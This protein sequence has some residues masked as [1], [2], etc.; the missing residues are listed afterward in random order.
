MTSASIRLTTSSYLSSQNKKPAR[1]ADVFWELEE[2]AEGEPLKNA[3][4][5]KWIKRWV[6][7]KHLLSESRQGDLADFSKMAGGSC[8]KVAVPFKAF[9]FFKPNTWSW[10]RRIKITLAL[11]R[12][13]AGKMVADSS[14]KARLLFVPVRGLNES[15]KAVLGQLLGNDDLR[16]LLVQNRF[17][18]QLAAPGLTN[19]KAS[20]LLLQAREIADEDD[21]ADGSQF[22]IALLDSVMTLPVFHVFMPE[23]WRA[24]NA[25]LTP[26][27]PVRGSPYRFI[28]ENA[29]KEEAL[30]DS[31]K[32]AFTASIEN[33]MTFQ[34]VGEILRM[35]KPI[36]EEKRDRAQYIQK[37]LDD[38]VFRLVSPEVRDLVRPFE[39]PVR[40]LMQ[41]G[42][43]ISGS[44]RL[45]AHIAQ[46]EEME[47]WEDLSCISTPEEM[48]VFLTYL[49]L[50]ND[51]KETGTPAGI[52][53]VFQILTSN[54]LPEGWREQCLLRLHIGQKELE[55]TKWVISLLKPDL[56][57]QDLDASRIRRRE[58]RL[59]RCLPR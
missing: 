57:P 44:L 14:R 42:D 56:L 12:S 47:R 7:S 17:D 53:E 22:G 1:N 26:D 33:G 35:I 6:L 28:L 36:V 34:E 51:S 21:N 16:R 11:G 46:L 9:V 48:I 32:E 55:N 8:V 31:W 43:R 40:V 13:R 39:D 18:E 2:Q 29:L 30:P 37:L 24:D 41:Q 4:P 20:R 15:E 59:A 49:L 23:P 10:L 25:E 45:E 27:L 58:D 3:V 54:P 5:D 52:T 38:P 50:A 19:K